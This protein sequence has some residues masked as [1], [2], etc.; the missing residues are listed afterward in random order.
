[1]KL[2]LSTFILL[3]FI[4]FSCTEKQEAN[5]EYQTLLFM[6]KEMQEINKMQAY[7][8]S[9]YLNDLKEELVMTSHDQ[10]Y[11]PKKEKL[12]YLLSKMEVINSESI[13]LI[14]EIDKMKL[15][16]LQSSGNKSYKITNKNDILPN[17]FDF[18]T[19]TNPNQNIQFSKIDKLLELVYQFRDITLNEC[20][21]YNLGNHSYQ[22]S[23]KPIQ[24]TN[25]VDD[26]KTQLE[27]A[28]NVQT[29]NYKEDK[30]LLFDL[31][32]QLS[33]SA[34]KIENHDQ[35]SSLITNL[36]LLSVIQQDILKSRTLANVHW[37]SKV[38]TGEVQFDTLFSFIEGSSE[39]NSG[40]SS[41]VKVFLGAMNTF[42]TPEITV[43]SP[44]D[45]TIIYNGDGTYSLSFS[46]KEKGKFELRGT[47]GIRNKSGFLISKEWEKIID[48]K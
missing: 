4:S 47:I 29:Y 48:V 7:T 31:Y 25:S 12:K 1:M 39:V 19:L 3:L 32:L 42:Q 18:T 33:E 40:T 28:L 27:Q 20:A 5:S 34:F 16:L 43:S 35:K 14:Q 13:K 11:L 45:A 21:N 6:E 23:L 2:T 46:P 17:Q 9:Y 24:I 41:T 22:L 26:F 36:S 44:K 8:G 37:K 30:K 38:S 15:E 10:I